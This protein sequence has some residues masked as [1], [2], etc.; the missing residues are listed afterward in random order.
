MVNV[1]LSRTLVPCLVAVGWTATA[2]AQTTTTT[3]TLSF[4]RLPGVYVVVEPLDPEIETHGLHA[5]T[6]RVLIESKLLDAGVPLMDE[7]QWQVTIGNPLAYLDLSLVRF[8][9]HLYLYRVQLE[10]RQLTVLARDSTIPVFTPTWKSP[11]TLGIV[12][13]NRLHTIREHVSRA[14]DHFVNA[15]LAANRRRWR[16]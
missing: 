3:D 1:I 11:Q 14:T 13:S 4:H 16:L 6:L 10:L 8:S 15:Y 2:G 12:Q 9:Q 7:D 5:D